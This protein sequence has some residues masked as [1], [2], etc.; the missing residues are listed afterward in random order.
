MSSFE[1][2]HTLDKAVSIGL[3][4][5]LTLVD[6]RD[7]TAFA[8]EEVNRE[9]SADI[10]IAEFIHRLG[11]PI[12]SELKRWIDE[13]NIECAVQCFRSAFTSDTGLEKLSPAPGAMELLEWMNQESYR[14]II[15]TSRMQSIA[16]EILQRCGMS[17]SVIYG[18]VTGQEKAVAMRQEGVAL[19][20]GDHPLDMEGAVAASVQGIGVTTGSHSA[21]QLYEAGAQAVFSSLTELRLQL[22]AR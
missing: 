8:L 7:A 6:T 16:A 17:P 9:L 21:S 11:P 22:K 1:S 4:L 15:I 20:V 2:T 5:D 12:R 13:Q 3:D 18:N 19:Y 10:D 14:S